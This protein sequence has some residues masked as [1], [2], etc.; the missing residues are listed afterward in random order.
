MMRQAE[1]G[2]TERQVEFAVARRTALPGGGSMAELELPAGGGAAPAVVAA[3]TIGAPAGAPPIGQRGGGRAGDDLRD[4]QERAPAVGL[5][6]P[7]KVAVEW[8]AALTLCV[9]TAPLLAA[10]AL[11]VKLSSPGPA[12]YLQTRLGRG[13]RSY[14]ICKLRTMAHNCEA[15]T[16]A[17]WATKDDV[18]ITPVGRVLRLTHLDEL[19]QLWNVLVG[20]MS[21]IGPRPERP[22]IVARIERDLPGYR[23][24]LAIR[25]G[26]TGLAQ[27]RLPADSD[28]ES[29]RRKLAHDMYYIRNLSPV[30]DARIAVCTVFYF[31]GAAAQAVCDSAVGTYAL[32]LR[33]ELARDAETVSAPAPAADVPAH[34]QRAVLAAD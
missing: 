24:R 9:L 4:V 31:V 34:D 13:G 25:P 16:G 15:T 2:I 27:M 5:Y 19:P 14:K 6:L 23:D 10:L 22:E 18:R 20:E 7:V 8:L 21:L 17:V 1:Y 30:M 28:L 3:E 11:L 12:L 33:N 29:V 26:V 32:A